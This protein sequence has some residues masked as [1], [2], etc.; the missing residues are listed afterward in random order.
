M[1]AKGSTA[2]EC[3]GGLNAGGVTAGAVAV[4]ISVG[5]AA[6]ESVT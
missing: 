4:V 6:C 2:I 3:A 5:A 1:F